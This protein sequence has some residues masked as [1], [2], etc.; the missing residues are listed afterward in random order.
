MD[1]GDVR[2]VLEHPRTLIGSDGWVLSA[3]SSDH[4]HPRN[5][6]CAPRLLTRYVRDDAVLGL[7]DAVAKLTGRAARRLGLA[8]RGRIAPGMAADV[9]VFDLERMQEGSTYA[10]PSVS[11]SGVEEVLVNGRQ[12]VIDGRPAGIREGRVLVRDPA[13]Q[14]GRSAREGAST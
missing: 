13:R 11:P 12:T 2:R 10:D 3:H 4:V 7:A 6:A 5:F 8:D 14:H 9:V 1:E